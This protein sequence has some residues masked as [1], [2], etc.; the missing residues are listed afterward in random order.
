MKTYYFFG[1]LFWAHYNK[2][3]SGLPQ[4]FI[5]NHFSLNFH[6]NQTFPKL[7]HL[8]TFIKIIDKLNCYYFIFYFNLISFI[9]KLYQQLTSYFF[10]KSLDY[11]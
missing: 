7:P 4:A 9:D 10:L 1:I 5:N 2:I 8:L 3:Y 6:F 11:F